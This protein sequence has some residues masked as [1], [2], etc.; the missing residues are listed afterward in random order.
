MAIE[1]KQ[2]SS[3]EKVFLTSDG[4]FVNIKKASALKGEKYS[5]QLAVKK[6]PDK[7]NSFVDLKIEINSPL[8]D[9]IKIYAVENIQG[10]LTHYKEMFGGNDDNYHTK[11]PGLFPELLIPDETVFKAKENLWKALWIEVNIPKNAVAGC[12]DINIILKD[13]GNS[14]DN[15]FSLEIINAV[16]PPQTLTYSN[17]FHADCLYTYYKVEPLSDEH[18]EIIYNFMETAVEYGMNTV[19]TPIFTPPL[20]VDRGG[21]RPTIQLVDISYE[22]NKYSFDFK[23]LKRWVDLAHKAGIKKFEIAHFFTQ[24]GAEAAPKI[25]VNGEKKFGWH[26]PADSPQYEE[27]LSQFVPALIGF[28]KDEGIKENSY[29]HVSDEPIEENLKGYL[30]AKNILTKYSQDMK[31][32][33]ALSHWEVYEKGAVE[34]PIVAIDSID[35]FI[36]KGAENI[37]AYNCCAQAVDVSNR[38]FDMPS[39]RNRI[40]ATQLFKFNITGFLHWGY[41]F[42]YAARSRKFINPFLTTDACGAFPSGDAFVVYPGDDGK[43][44]KSLRLIVLNEAF[45]DMRAFELASEYIGRDKVIEMI[46]EKTDITFRNFPKDAEFILNL[47]EKINKII[48]ENN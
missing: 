29:F 20:D 40:I 41:N 33:D 17:W 31:I 42:Y 26:T 30:T 48:K 46:D 9:Y 37:Y 32:T 22:N 2:I 45:Q 21:E 5:Y 38:Y 43:P 19:L 23:N 12:Y 15:I 39:Q 16:L 27:F 44:L 18:F 1:I 25:I 6:I 3:L 35:E 14:F 11:A 13:G 8:K 36:K 47:R 4:N 10:E 34:I 28:L 7:E 24:W